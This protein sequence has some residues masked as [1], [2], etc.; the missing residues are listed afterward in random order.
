MLE[1][2]GE[3]ELPKIKVSAC[4]VSTHPQSLLQGL[5]G[6]RPWVTIYGTQ[7]EGL[8]GGRVGVELCLD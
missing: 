8:P 3:H 7:M 1:G 6:N 2:E 4:S 5:A